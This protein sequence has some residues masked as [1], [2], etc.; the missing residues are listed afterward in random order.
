MRLF[1]IAVAIAAAALL[2]GCD[3]HPDKTIKIKGKDGNITISGDNGHMTVKSDDGKTT[4]EINSN[5]LGN[6]RLPDFA[7]AYPGGQV[8]VS[9]ASQT[10]RGGT[11]A[12]E[13]P[14]APDKVIAFY[15]DRAK[16]AGLEEKLNMNANG[17]LTFMASAGE[18]KKTVQVIAGKIDTGSHVQ[19]FWA[20]K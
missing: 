12:F 20:D 13:T 7:P 16:S 4:V 6:Q 2:A 1:T 15:K 9:V 3:Q 19:V 11:F 14:D 8:K 5:S 18:D 10:E 17:A